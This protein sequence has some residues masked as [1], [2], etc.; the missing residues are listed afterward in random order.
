MN[1]FGDDDRDEDTPED[2][3]EGMA[4]NGMGSMEPQG[5]QPPKSNPLMFGHDGVQ[6]KIL[7]QFNAGKM[8]HGLILSGPEGVGKLTFAYRLVRF[9]L[10]RSVADPA[11]DALFAEPEP[12]AATSLDISS[13]SPVFARIAAGGHSD[14]MVVERAY[15]EAKNIHKS[16]VD[17]ASIRKVAPFLRMTAAEGG[18]RAVI[19]NDADTMNRNAQNALLKILEEPPENTVLILVTHRIGALLPTIRSRTQTLNFT[20]LP[21]DD[22][23]RLLELQGHHLS[24]QEL[25]TLYA[26]SEGSISK[27][28]T[29]LDEGGLDVME[30]ILQNLGTYP[31]IPMSTVHSFAETLSRPNNAAAYQSF[32]ATMQWIAGSLCKMKARDDA[33]QVGPLNIPAFQIMFEKSRLNQI[34]NMYDALQDHFAVVDHGNLEKRW[35]VLKAFDIFAKV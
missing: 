6:D 32:A 29:L 2:I 20:A 12:A 11:Q 24:A 33:V 10:S 35:A 16:G 26:L 9:L 13:D 18:W 21:K 28:L 5:L 31:D 1:L 27:A 8:P 14:F 22:M 15:D 19:V 34:V 23:R 3:E 30:Q 4:S 17:V 7:S 25:D